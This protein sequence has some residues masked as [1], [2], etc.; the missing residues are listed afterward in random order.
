MVDQTFK[1]SLFQASAGASAGAGIFS[2]F[3]QKRA[4]KS[5]EQ[6][7][8]LQASQEELGARQQGLQRARQIREVMAQQSVQAA[9]GGAEVGSGAFQSV[10]RSSFSAFQEDNEIE[11]LNLSVNKAK[12][13]AE[14]KN[15]RDRTASGMF[16][17]FAKLATNV[18]TG[19][20]L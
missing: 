8:E 4:G 7:L 5:Q 14:R 19:G 17:T 16:D 18:V 11:A 1:S 13:A 12:T 3:A 20:L 9:V 6:L 2:M 10:Q 15:I